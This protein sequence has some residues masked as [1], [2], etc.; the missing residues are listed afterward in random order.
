MSDHQFE[1]KV[2]QK[3]D[4]LRFH[5]SDAVWTQVEK[6]IAAKKRRRRGLIW[7]PVF[8][9]LSVAG[10]LIYTNSPSP[11]QTVQNNPSASESVPV[12][13]TSVEQKEVNANK[14][15]HSEK[16]NSVAEIENEKYTSTPSGKTISTEHRSNDI[17]QKTQ[18]TSSKRKIARVETT[19][20]HLIIKSDNA[21]QRT[22]AFNGNKKTNTLNKDIVPPTSSPVVPIIENEVENTDALVNETKVVSKDSTSTKAIA[23]SVLNSTDSVQKTDMLAMVA[24]RLIKPARKIQLGFIFQ[25]G[26]S[27]ISDGGFLDFSQKSRVQDVASISYSQ[28]LPM[29]AVIPK[30][31]AIRGGLA[32][33][34]GIFVKQPIG[35]MLSATAGINYS[36]MQTRI[37]VG[38]EVQSSSTVYNSGALMNVS[39]YYQ[40]GADFS[41]RNKYHFIEI[42]VHLQAKL[43][44]NKTIPLTLEAGMVLSRMIASNALHF[45]GASRVYYSDNSL[46]NK[47]QVGFTG[48]FSIGLFEKSKHPLSVGPFVHY[49]V[50]NLMRREVHTFRHLYSFGLES[51]WTWK[52]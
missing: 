39:D 15:V 40:S 34:A 21:P 5:P 37:D 26:I 20:P 29:N 28:P 13:K 32:L 23:P 17:T 49:R 47:T 43:N 30:P 4:E 10:F 24:P 2:R 12:E 18:N 22:N 46:I 27:R 38:H 48:A 31:S 50:S 9:A 51:R 52:K 33:T 7:F 11:L 8:I 41:Y 19:V 45:D 35:K 3:L 36:L 14:N 25:A 42:P 44:R 1:K 6:R 16:V